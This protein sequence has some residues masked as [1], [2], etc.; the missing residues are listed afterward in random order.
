MDNL[1]GVQDIAAKLGV[2]RSAVHKWRQRH[3]DFPKPVATLGGDGA[4]GRRFLVWDWS[5]VQSWAQANNYPR[6]KYDS[7]D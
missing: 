3:E 4:A 7:A 2:E 5:D 6:P 1:V